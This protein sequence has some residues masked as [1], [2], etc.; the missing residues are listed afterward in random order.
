MTLAVYDVLGR[1]VRT[2]VNSNVSPGYYEVPFDGSG[3]ASGVYFYR[4]S[5]GAFS[6]VKK[7]L[8]LK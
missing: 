8:L 6:K 4:I 5:T 3:L 7:M 1:L 2:L